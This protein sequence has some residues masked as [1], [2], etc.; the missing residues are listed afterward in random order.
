[1]FVS[2]TRRAAV[3]V[4]STALAIIFAG[5]ALPSA[6]AAG[7][8]PAS[9]VGV[10]RVTMALTVWSALPIPV[11]ALSAVLLVCLGL[12]LGATWTIQAMQPNLRRRAE[13]RR[14]LNEEWA[15]VRTIRLRQTVCPRCGNPLSTRDRYTAPTL[16]QDP[17]E[18]E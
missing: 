10:R 4:T 13:E 14:R 17:D 9:D 18:D 15:T 6:S 8:W 1:M 3:L 11:Q 12:L 2:L 7:D 16:V 5:V